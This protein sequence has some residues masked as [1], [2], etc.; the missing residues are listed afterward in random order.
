[1]G[2]F[3]I[4]QRFNGDYQFNLKA[5]NGQIILTSEGYT[6]KEGCKNGIE[7]VKIYSIDDSRFDRRSA[8]NG[9]YYFNLR[10]K[11]GEIIGTSEIYQSKNGME[12]GI[13][14][15]KNNAPKAVIEDFLL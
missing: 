13:E 2:K 9:G 11:N 4:S 14:A 15:V 3:V 5:I 8:T 10:A 12:N 1:M 6:S 7:A